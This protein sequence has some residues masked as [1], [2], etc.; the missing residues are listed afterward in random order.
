[1]VGK[2]NQDKAILGITQCLRRIIKSLQNYSSEVYSHFGITGPQ[3]WVL[4]T[5]YQN[6]SLPLGELS[7]RMYLHPSTLTAAV[8]RLEK[9]GYVF[10]NR[11]EK[12]RRVINVQLTPKGNSLAKRAP[13]PI[14]GKMI[15]G[16]RKLKKDEVFL[17]YRSV[18][19]LVEIMEAEKV[20]V[21]FLFDKEA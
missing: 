3:L 13:K 19:K 15:Y 17:I 7:K 16:L 12:D 2:A 8:D 21:T 6:G 11:I 5:I 14:Q 9:K 18:E 1:M 4:K 20:K 10:R